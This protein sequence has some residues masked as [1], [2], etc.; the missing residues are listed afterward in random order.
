MSWSH[1]SAVRHYLAW[2][3]RTPGTGSLPQR[4]A[5]WVSMNLCSPFTTVSPTLVLEKQSSS[6]ILSFPQS[7]LAVRQEMP[8]HGGGTLTCSVPWVLL[9]AGVKMAYVRPY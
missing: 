8:L 3:H 6:L 2:Q 1:L 7:G 5:F 9:N 4:L